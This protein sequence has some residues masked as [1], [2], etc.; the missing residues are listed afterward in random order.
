VGARVG[1]SSNA[2]LEVVQIQHYIERDSKANA[3]Q[4]IG[5]LLDAANRLKNYPLSGRVIQQWNNPARRELIVGSYRLMYHVSLSDIVVFSVR[6]TRRRVPKRFR[7]E[8]LE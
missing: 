3:V 8:W 4:V 5:R 7:N 6:H 1:W 2:R